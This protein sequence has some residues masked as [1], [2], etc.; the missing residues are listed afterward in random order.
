[1]PFSLSTDWGSEWG[2]YWG[3]HVSTG[4]DR[5]LQFCRGDRFS[6]LMNLFADR[7]DDMIATAVEIQQ[8]FDL[9]SAT[10]DR[11]DKLGEILVRPRRG[12]NDTRYRTLLQI[13]VQLL[14]TSASTTPTIQ[15][16]VELYT[17]AAPTEYA[18]NYP[19][20]Y[21]IGALIND[22][23]DL[24]L[25]EQLI[26]EATSAAYRST[27]HVVSAGWLRL[28]YTPASPVADAGILGYTPSA[29]VAGAGTLSY[30]DVL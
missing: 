4:S 29:P 24:P 13:Q 22:P 26:N 2:E 3:D 6:A 15:R 19:M 10:G 11:L 12:L 16:I 25:L 9:E 28:D 7:T 14:L 27:I 30:T 8:A 18:E 17:G 5:I 21:S 1:M 23:A 20:G